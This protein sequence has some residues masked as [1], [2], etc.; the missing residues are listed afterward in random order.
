MA[1]VTA[2]VD[3]RRWSHDVSILI[4]AGAGVGRCFGS[5]PRSKVSM[6]IMRAPQHGHGR[7][8]THS[9]SAELEEAGLFRVQAERELCQSGARASRRRSISWGSTPQIIE[10]FILTPGHPA[11]D[12]PLITHP[13]QVHSG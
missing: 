9:I 12:E 3:R 1:L 11:G 7:G 2:V 10:K 13:H 4:A 6:T 5:Q 8:S